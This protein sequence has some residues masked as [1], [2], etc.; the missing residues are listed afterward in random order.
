[1]GYRYALHG[2]GIN[3]VARGIPCYSGTGCGCGNR[4]EQWVLYAFRVLLVRPLAGYVR[5]YSGCRRDR[6]REKE[7]GDRGHQGE[8]GKEERRKWGEKRDLCEA[9]ASVASERFAHAAG[10]RRRRR[11]RRQLEDDDE[12]RWQRRRRRRRR[13]ADERTFRRKRTSENGRRAEMKEKEKDEKDD[14]AAVAAC[15]WTLASE[16][17][18]PLALASLSRDLSLILSLRACLVLSL[19]FVPFLVRPT[20]VSLTPIALL[21]TRV[22]S[23]MRVVESQF[24]ERE[25]EAE[26]AERS[27]RGR[28]KEWQRGGWKRRKREEAGRTVSLKPNGCNGPETN[29]DQELRERRERKTAELLC[30]TP[31]PP[32]SLFPFACPFFTPSFL[33]SS[34]PPRFVA[35]IINISPSSC[36]TACSSAHRCCSFFS[37]SSSSSSSSCITPARL[38]R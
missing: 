7:N 15:E 34:L 35:P 36:L 28:T 3:A 24:R 16:H 30:S 25:T 17:F 29:L 13:S 27:G 10:R 12:R 8:T 5:L 4:Q 2:R 32:P 14:N 19:S 33:Y 38:I 1:M 31:S 23:W 20:S 26:R 21:S 11:G 6:E 18:R 37:W 9:A 22:L